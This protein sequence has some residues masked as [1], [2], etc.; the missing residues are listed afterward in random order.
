MSS[1]SVKPTC[2]Y[3]VPGEPGQPQRRCGE[4]AKFWR[5][6]HA[7][8]FHYCAMCA[9]RATDLCRGKINLHP[10]REES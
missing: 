2:D 4:P 8:L 6:G 1:V 7:G 9:Q 3:L 10:L 5:N